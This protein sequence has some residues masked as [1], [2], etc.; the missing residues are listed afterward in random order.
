MEKR[1]A[2]STRLEEA[3]AGLLAGGIGNGEQLAEIGRLGAKLVLQRALEEEVTDFLQR[4]RYE[5]TGEAQGS[6]NGVRPKRV[7]TAQGELELAVPQLRDTAERFVSGAT[8]N[9]EI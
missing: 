4:A 1:I 6:R 8:T 3:I 5:R 7:Q 2:P 9:I